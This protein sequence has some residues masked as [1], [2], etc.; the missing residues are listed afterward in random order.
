MASQSA[1]GT[2]SNNIANVNTDGYSRQRVELSANL[3]QFTGGGYIGQG[4]N[5]ATVSRVYDQFI[6]NQLT[7]S[8]SAFGEANTLSTLASQVDNITSNEA[9]GLSSGLKSFFSAANGVANNPTSLPARQ[10]MLTEASSLSQQFNRLSSQ[11]DA[12]RNQT[13]GEMQSTVDDINALAKNIAELNGKIAV[14][15]TNSL[16]SQKPNDLLDQRDALI[17]KL[18]QKVSVTAIPQQ[19]GSI[20]L[21]IGK[22]QALVLG[23]STAKLSLVGSANDPSHK[24]VLLDGHNVGK[25]INGGE[26]S[27][28]IKFRDQVLDPA[29]Q[30]L[31]LVAAGVTVQFNA[32]HTT[33]FDLNGNAGTNMF[34]LGTPALNVPVIANPANVGSIAASY[35]P[36]TLGQLTPSDYN[37]SYDGSTFSLTRL[38]DNTVTTFAGP[39]PTTIAGPGFSIATGPTVAANDSFLIRP[40]YN[41]AQNMTTLIS[42]PT[43]IAAA[44]TTGGPGSPISGDNTVALGLASLENNPVLLG[45]KS[46]FSNAYGQLVSQVGTLTSSAK[47]S[48]S[49]QQAL[50]NQATQSRESLAGVNLDEEAA[51]MLKYQQSYQAAAKVVSVASSL[52]DTLI[53]AINR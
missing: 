12:M 14:V 33:G 5:V 23:T 2:I 16:D 41:A 35:N 37:L 24:D 50:L 13:N 40:T 45:G 25:D 39:P 32:L 52:F 43:K 36:S 47:V 26:L 48:S 4:V 18:A 53:G 42:D 29:Q 3:P 31:G 17:N 6:N 49:A 27:G 19:N 15:A 7:A 46:T 11:F 20:D 8:T 22:G 44:G 30:Q 51:N 38:S 34:S 28:A 9:T 21:V 10:V 1:L